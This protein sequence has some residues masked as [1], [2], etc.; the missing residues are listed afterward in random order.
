MKD[1]FGNTIQNNFYSVYNS[2]SITNNSKA[3]FSEN[4]DGTFT[5]YSQ[6]E[7]CGSY[8]VSFS[9]P[10]GK[11]YVINWKVNANF[12][13]VSVNDFEVDVIGTPS[14]DAG[15]YVQANVNYKLISILKEEDKAALEKVLKERVVLY[16]FSKNGIYPFNFTKRD[17]NQIIFTSNDRL[18]IT[19]NYEIKA[20]K[21]DLP[22]RCG[23]CNFAINPLTTIDRFQPYLIDNGEF[24]PLLENYSQI[25]S[26]P[27]STQ[28]L[29]TFF[30][31]KLDKYGN[32]IFSASTSLSADIKPLGSNETKIS[33]CSVP[34]PSSYKV[35]RDYLEICAGD[36]DKVNALNGNFLFTDPLSKRYNLLIT[37]SPLGSSETPDKLTSFLQNV[38][39]NV[40]TAT[41][42]TEAIVVV[43]LRDNNGK[44]SSSYLS[45]KIKVTGLTDIDVK[46]FRNTPSIGLFSLIFSTQKII[47][48]SDNVKFTITYNNISIIEN[49]TFVNNPGTLA[50]VSYTQKQYIF[51]NKYYFQFKLEDQAK[52][53]PSL[54]NKNEYEP[55]FFLSFLNV[56][57]DKDLNIRYD[58][59]LNDITGVYN[60]IVEAGSYLSST[61]KFRYGL[62]GSNTESVNIL[63]GQADPSKSYASVTESVSTPYAGDSAVINFSLLDSNGI[64]IDLTQKS[65]DLNVYLNVMVRDTLY[66]TYKYLETK[67]YVYGKAAINPFFNYNFPIPGDYIFI[68]KLGNN[69]ISCVRCRIFVNQKA[70]DVDLSK[71]QLF[72]KV[73]NIGWENI[74]TSES[75]SIFQS[76]FPFFRLI[77]NDS[78]GTMVRLDSLDKYTFTL[79]S[80][81]GKKTLNIE[82]YQ[83]K[84]NGILIYLSATER[85]KWLTLDSLTQ[86]KL[87]VVDNG[88]SNNKIQFTKLFVFN[89]GNMSSQQNTCKDPLIAKPE[90]YQSKDIFIRSGN[91]ALV[92]F[93]L[94]NCNIRANDFVDPTTISLVMTDPNIQSNY[95]VVIFPAE[96][97]GTYLAVISSRTSRVAT[98]NI[99]YNRIKSSDELTIRVVYNLKPASYKIITA[100]SY[101]ANDDYGTFS[102]VV[103]DL[104]GN[105]FNREQSLF[106]YN[107]IYLTISFNKSPINYKITYSNSQN[108]FL[109]Q[110]PIQ[111]RGEYTIE[112]PYSNEKK[113]LTVN[114]GTNLMNSYFNYTSTTSSYILNIY[115]FDAKYNSISM[116]I[117]LSQWKIYYF[118]IDYITRSFNRSIFDSSVLKLDNNKI[119]INK[120]LLSKGHVGYFAIKTVVGNE[121]IIS[122]GPLVNE[123]NTNIYS[124]TS[125]GQLFNFLERGSHMFLDSSSALP[126]LRSNVLN[127]TVQIVY[128]KDRVDGESA[129]TLPPTTVGL[130]TYF[131]GENKCVD[132]SN[133]IM[134]LK[135]NDNSTTIYQ[136]LQVT[137]VSNQTAP[138]TVDSSKVQIIGAFSRLVFPAG[139]SGLLF[140]QIRDVK[141]VPVVTSPPITLKSDIKDTKMYIINSYFNGVYLVEVTNINNLAL[142]DTATFVIN[143]NESNL[144]FS[145]TTLPYFPNS[146][147]IQGSETRKGT[148]VRYTINGRDKFKNQVCDKRLNIKIYNQNLLSWRIHEDHNNLACQIEVNF[149]GSATIENIYK[150][151][152]SVINIEDI[153][154]IDYFNSY[155]ITTENYL[156]SGLGAKAKLLLILLSPLGTLYDSSLSTKI[157]LRFYRLIDL[158]IRVLEQ[159]VNCPFSCEFS[160]Q[161][162]GDYVY[163]T[164][165]NGVELS[166]L[167]SLKYSHSIKPTPNSFK[168]F[169][170]VDY[171]AEVTNL[172]DVTPDLKFDSFTETI[173]YPFNYRVSLT[174]EDNEVI[175]LPENVTISLNIKPYSSKGIS[176]NVT[177]SLESMQISET[178]VLI[179]LPKDR[180]SSFLHIPQGN[181]VL[182]FTV[183]GNNFTYQKALPFVISGSKS[184][185]YPKLTYSNEGDS[186]PVEIDIMGFGTSVSR[187]S[188][189]LNYYTT[190]PICIV[191]NLVDKVVYN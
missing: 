141:G 77:V 118:S 98:A 176:E 36:I 13:T 101:S 66:S 139:E 122:T 180:S 174:N 148:T 73:S 3:R 32:E 45:D 159:T 137:Y 125:N 15:N 115:Q 25:I 2:I 152:R 60:V 31:K 186:L 171:W 46:V 140:I 93:S 149:L 47:K 179:T 18:N 49:I 52:S 187:I 126:I 105:P 72:I 69:E 23:F 170:R 64:S 102:V 133:L 68:P 16:A 59:S 84:S 42:D 144:S 75:Y 95:E 145:I 40:V 164:V 154:S 117:D 108:S 146:V 183:V 58:Y 82:K 29:P 116:N 169:K 1:L 92:L 50:K 6:G 150:E 113:V 21:D 83:T 57:N 151:K 155:V 99:V 121:L 160:P 184:F 5:L 28:R 63:I 70:N 188:T 26:L 7:D 67:S 96:K 136:Q 4:V 129:I 120:S 54:F 163:S 20:F 119:E 161:K 55:R 124:F 162:Y 97:Y 86:L 41:V 189:N 9:L 71:S 65:S 53:V 123:V 100:D 79:S 24:L 143:N 138:G 14:I 87:T 39:Q 130:S 85:T 111:G 44:R 51:E 167:S 165:V 94:Q 134:L 153:P 106:F 80:T 43:D 19:D 38:I 114:G 34:T 88:N 35:T 181:Y 132:C 90:G 131:S 104:N 11:Q 10:T 81:D 89:A 127:N 22:L 74:Y 142:S 91:D 172:R 33:L 191:N 17:V 78:F 37:S 8:S 158:N 110:F 147:D 190:D 56:I 182:V 112:Y 173:D 109:V 103:T 12:T 175:P 135:L 157:E 178:R 62:N 76:A 156:S 185:Q 30:L 61:L 48:P 107:D 27:N 168:V 177:L 128:K 166:N